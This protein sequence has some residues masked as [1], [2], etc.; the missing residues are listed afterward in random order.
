MQCKNCVG[1]HHRIVLISKSGNR[2][3]LADIEDVVVGDEFVADIDADDL[4]ENH[5][6]HIVWGI[7]R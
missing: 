7:A 2:S 5:T 3:H 4:A 1:I 6:I